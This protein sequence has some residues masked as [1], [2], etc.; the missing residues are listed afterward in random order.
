MEDFVEDIQK[1]EKFKK[2][3]EKE[4]LNTETIE[5]IKE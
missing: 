1:S 2:Q 5:E 4:R 3:R